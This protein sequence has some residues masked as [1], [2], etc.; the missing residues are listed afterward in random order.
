MERACVNAVREA[1]RDVED[2]DPNIIERV[3][4]DNLVANGRDCVNVVLN[5]DFWKRT[6]KAS[7]DEE[8][9]QPMDSLCEALLQDLR[10]VTSVIVNSLTEKLTAESKATPSPQ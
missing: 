4:S 3:F 9:K 8:G 5:D 10:C 1:W 6:F 2:G 7:Q